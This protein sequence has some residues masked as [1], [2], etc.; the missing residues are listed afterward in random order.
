MPFLDVKTG[1]LT[2]ENGVRFISHMDKAELLETL[3]EA[4]CNSPDEGACSVIAF[5]S[6]PVAGGMLAAFCIL[7]EE[8]LQSVS[9]TVT[10]VGQKTAPSAEQQRS[11]LFHCFAV[12]DPCPDTQ[13]NCEL[14]CEFGI[15]TLCTDPRGGSAIGRLS[16]HGRP[17][18]QLPVPGEYH[19]MSGEL[20]RA[21]HPNFSA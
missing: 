2:F 5:P 21:D 19:E 4:G 6:C 3:R 16:Y 18:N 13:R 7:W 14:S 12:K 9:L 11:F 8:R 10:S 15:I 17:P 1:M 20:A